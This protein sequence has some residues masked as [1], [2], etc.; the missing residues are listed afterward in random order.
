MS[1]IV[2]T[3]LDLARIPSPTGREAGVAEYV[4]RELSALGFTV[5]FDETQQITG[6]D[7]GNL[8]ATLPATVPG[9]CVAF[10]AHMDCVDPCEGVEPVL[11]GG[12]IRTAGDTVLG[13]DDKVGVAA[14]IEAAKRL[15]ESGEPHAELRLL[16]TVSEEQGLIGAKALSPED[17]SAD[18]CLV[19]DADGAVGGIVTA[20]PTHYTFEATF[21][22]RAV[23]AGVEPEKGVSAIVIASAAIAGMELG[24]LDDHSTANI[25]TIAGGSATNVVAPTCMVTGE[26]RSL[27][28]RRVEAVREAMDGAM[29]DAATAHG[30]AVEVAWTLAY[31]GFVVPADAPAAALVEAACADIEVESRMFATGGG[32]DANVFAALGVPALVLASGMAKVHS[33][34]EELEVV[35][36]ERLADLIIALI[37]RAVA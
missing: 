15:A 6:S 33:T 4:A 35:Q 24:R 29:R 5:R 19:L 18:V 23:H 21:T 22:G 9:M 14:M 13:G 30:G 27:D 26:C 32:S 37:R 2:D 12:V 25:G 20:A 17:A 16:F 36:L 28:R 1:R 8:I 11:E 7:S 10:A 31:E 34:D 3:F